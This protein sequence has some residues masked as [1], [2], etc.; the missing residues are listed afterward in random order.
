M[1]TEDVHGVESAA[2]EESVP[3]TGEVAVGRNAV[4]GVVLVFCAAPAL[5]SV[6]QA[7]ERRA[8]AGGPAGLSGEM[9]KNSGLH[10]E[11]IEG[12]QHARYAKSENT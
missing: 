11:K 7:E 2:G 9:N 8:A 4:L 6:L 5:A 10:D 12:L 1:L 3:L